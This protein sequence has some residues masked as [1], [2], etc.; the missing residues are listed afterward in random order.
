V[1]ASL[2]KRQEPQHL[3]YF[4]CHHKKAGGAWTWRGYRNYEDTR[5]IIQGEDAQ[6][7]AATISLSEMSDM[8]QIKDF[9][10]PPVVFFN[11]CESAQ[12]DIGDPTSFMLYFINVLKAYA[13]IGTE[14]DI[15]GAFA[16]PFGI[17]FVEKFL[18]AH[19]IGEI[20]YTARRDFAKRYNNP[21][22]LYYTLYGNGNVQLAQAI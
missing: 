19:P 15:P 9:Q 20:L 6:A 8:E 3:L 7:D 21:F 1:I 4:F 16:H 22:G 17:R 18:K 2:T 5:M 13:F 12:V 10:F 14:A 11:A